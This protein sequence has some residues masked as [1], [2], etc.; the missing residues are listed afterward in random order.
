MRGESIDWKFVNGEGRVSSGALLGFWKYWA[1]APC[2]VKHG[3]AKEIFGLR[4]EV[5]H[6]CCRE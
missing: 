4:T 6:F 3:V 5:P 2:L 1:L